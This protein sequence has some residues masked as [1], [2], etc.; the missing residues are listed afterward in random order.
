MPRAYPGHDGHSWSVAALFLPWFS[1]RL[2]L[3]RSPS[4]YI[5][6]HLMTAKNFFS[7]MTQNSTANSPE[8]S[9]SAN[10]TS[11]GGLYP[12]S[13]LSATVQ[14]PK[15]LLGEGNITVTNP[16]LPH[17]FHKHPIA[18]RRPWGP[19]FQDSSPATLP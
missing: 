10:T 6:L 13:A 7:S 8:S 17:D 3:R 16:H 14:N 18:E 1:R 15:P 12:T 11:Q 4:I 19:H 9:L 2:D 5:R